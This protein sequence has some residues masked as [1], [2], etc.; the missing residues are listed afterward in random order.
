MVDTTGQAADFTLLRPQRQPLRQSVAGSWRGGEVGLDFEVDFDDHFEVDSPGPGIFQYASIFSNQGNAVFDR[1]RQFA[2]NYL[3]ADVPLLSSGERWR[4]A[5]G[6]LFGLSLA[7][8]LLAAMPATG[9]SPA[10][11]APMGAS[12]VILFALPLSPLAQPWSVLGGYLIA[13]LTAV[14]C[15]FLVPHAVLAAALAVG[16]TIWLSSRLVCLHPPSGALAILIVFDHRLAPGHTVDLVLLALGNVLAMV[17][18]ALLVNRLLLR[19]RYPHCRAEQSKRS[20]PA[21]DTRPALRIGLSH[22]DLSAAV[23]QVDGYLDIQDDD[24]LQVY[25]F[26]VDHAFE[27]HLALRCGDIMRSDVRTLEFAS[28]LQEAWDLL[29]SG[30]IQALPIL[31][32]ISK[33]VLGIVTLTDFLRQIEGSAV[34]SLSLQMRELLK[35]NPTTSSEKAEV[36]GQIMSATPFSVSAQTPVVELVKQ[37]VDNGLQHIPVVDEKKRF[38]GLI[39][40]IDLTAALYQHIAL[41]RS[42]AAPDFPPVQENPLCA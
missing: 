6:A 21:V 7:A 38:V 30:R 11:I 34:A 35:R 4:S 12:A 24:L 23:Q 2:L 13:A 8:A 31:D 18:A 16:M 5:L 15:A 20:D 25:R 32:R 26:A 40:Q 3:I 29:Q 14:T 41:E 33:R 39:S 17:A 22:A 37:W 1:I 28:D 10:L 9:S 27:R 42:K 36:V 19:R